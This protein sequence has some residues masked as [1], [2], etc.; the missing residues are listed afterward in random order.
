MI[1]HDSKSIFI[2]IPK[3]G[4]TSIEK[5]LRNV[6]EKNWVHEPDHRNAKDYFNLNATQ[7][8]RYHKFTVVRDPVERELSLYRFLVKSPKRKTLS[9]Y[10]DSIIS[11][12]N[13]YKNMSKTYHHLFSNQVDYFLINEQICVDQIIRFEDL[14]NGFDLLSNNLNIDQKTLPHLRKTYIKRH[15]D[16]DLDEINKIKKIRQKDYDL[17]GY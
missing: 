7:F 5:T 6:K 4:G 1:C 12:D 3:T 16:P 8:W 10:L 9:Q 11:K 17:L 13:F 2:H 14:Q 15:V